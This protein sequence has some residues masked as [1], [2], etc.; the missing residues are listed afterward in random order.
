MGHGIILSMGSKIEDDTTFFNIWDIIEEQYKG[1]IRFCGD[2]DG[3]IC[4]IK[5]PQDTTTV[6]LP[7]GAKKFQLQEV[8]EN[9]YL[10]PE[11]ARPI[12]SQKLQDN[13]N[14]SPKDIVE[15]I[16]ELLG[17]CDSYGVNLTELSQYSFILAPGEKSIIYILPGTYATATNHIG[18]ISYNKLI[19]TIF[20]DRDNSDLYSLFN[21]VY[22]EQFTRSIS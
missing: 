21:R 5:E 10:I 8:A 2:S 4:V 19:D 15:K 3:Q 12:Y 14:L 16:A 22:N 7:Q 18:R 17:I 11:S 6:P 1:K 9:I 13:G 20:L